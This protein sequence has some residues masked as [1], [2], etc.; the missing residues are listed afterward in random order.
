MLAE[1][2]NATS[3]ITRIFSKP[4]VT[5]FYILVS[6]DENSFD[7]YSVDKVRNIRSNLAEDVKVRQKEKVSVT[8]LSLYACH[9]KSNLKTALIT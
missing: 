7:L 3:N 4:A 1:R 5:T 8:H 6:T 9:V 2:H